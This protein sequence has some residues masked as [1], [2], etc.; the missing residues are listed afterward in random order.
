[1]IYFLDTSALVKRFVSERGSTEVRHL[2]TRGRV[3]AASRLAYPELVASTVRMWREGRM[4]EARRDEILASIPQCIAGLNLVV[5]VRG[6][7]LAQIAA[8]LLRRALRAYDAVQLASALLIKE[9]GAVDFWS[10]DARL[11]EAAKAEKLRTTLVG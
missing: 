7:L 6:P 9:S 2:F 1:M 11:V 8:L 10:A 4:T 5:E 3:L